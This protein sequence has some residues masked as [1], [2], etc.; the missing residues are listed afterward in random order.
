MEMAFVSWILNIPIIYSIHIHHTE[1]SFMKLRPIQPKGK[2]G[3]T[4]PAF[5][6]DAVKLRK[7]IDYL[8]SLGYE[9]DLGDSLTST[10]GFFAGSDSLRISE[11]H[12]MFAD[13]EI[14]AIICA[15][16]GWGTLRLLD[17]L[18]YNLIKSNPKPLVGY[19]DI[20]TLQLAIWQQ[21]GLPSLSGP[22][23]A[24]EM[25]NGILP[26]TAKHFW[27]QINNLQNDYKLDLEELTAEIWQP[28]SA[29]GTLLGGCLS[30]ISH[31]L[32]TP[33]SPDYT[34]AILFLEDVGEEPYKIDRYLA[35]L[36]QAG[37]FDRIAGLIICDFLDCK[38]SNE[39][40]K[41]IPVREVLKE[42]FNDLDIPTISGFPYGHGMKKVTMP[43]GV[44]ARLNTERRS[45]VFE[46]PFAREASALS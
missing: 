46:N 12:R 7:G 15:R 13:P 3:I 23:V 11:L 32:G 14:E 25:G 2:I 41:G 33:Y 43:M 6:P 42:Y 1:S 19:S 35:H 26:F 21:T 20:T 5:P 36:R 9:I 40:R 8:L 10:H 38:D 28:G 34:G 16:G 22:M 31:Q 29:S 18:D 4:A 37:V 30:M 17:Q 39:A 27:D 45:L 44:N 24:V